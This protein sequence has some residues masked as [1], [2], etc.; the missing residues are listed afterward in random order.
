MAQHGQNIRRQ[1][2]SCW[3]TTLVIR[4]THLLINC[5]RRRTRCAWLIDRNPV[6]N[7]WRGKAYRPI[8]KNGSRSRDVYDEWPRPASA[9]VSSITL[10]DRGVPNAPHVNDAYRDINGITGEAIGDC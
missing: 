9:P 6:Y 7:R 2:P 10:I 3:Q 5:H 8:S 1:R 4:L